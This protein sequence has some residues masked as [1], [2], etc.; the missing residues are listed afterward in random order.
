MSYAI[1]VYL[2]KVPVQKNIISF[3]AYVTMFPQLVAGPIVKYGDVA[4]Q[5]K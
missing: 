1:D 2:D 3:G 5:L 4:K